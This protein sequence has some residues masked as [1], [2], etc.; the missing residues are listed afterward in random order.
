ME[1][2]KL[3][4]NTRKLS[5]K[6]ALEGMKTHN[7]EALAFATA[8]NMVELSI[9]LGSTVELMELLSKW[10]AKKVAGVEV[11]D[12]DLEKVLEEM[13]HNLELATGPVTG[14]A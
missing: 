1:K 2:Q 11:K 13:Q 14:D 4:Q 10:I 8:L 6:L 12:G 5:R 9:M 7:E 3:R